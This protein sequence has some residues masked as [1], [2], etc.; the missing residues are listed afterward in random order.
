M[1]THP[2][3]ESDFDCLTD[4]SRFIPSLGSTEVNNEAKIRVPKKEKKISKMIS[5][6]IFLDDEF[7]LADLR[8][9]IPNKTL[10]QENANE[11][12]EFSQVLSQIVSELDVE[13]KKKLSKK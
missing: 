10:V 8:V 11:E 2:I 12:W 13:K 6:R 5:S 7:D 3:F 9:Q 1:G 4:M